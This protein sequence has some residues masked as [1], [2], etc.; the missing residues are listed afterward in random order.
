MPPTPLANLSVGMM[1]TK[2][3]G[4]A[5]PWESGETQDQEKAGR[6]GQEFSVPF[7][8]SSGN[9]C[10]LPS[11]Q[12]PVNMLIFILTVGLYGLDLPS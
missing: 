4:G 8:R 12:F 11:G 6:Q 7:V 1:V 2:G 9:G 3:Q 10:C 5:L